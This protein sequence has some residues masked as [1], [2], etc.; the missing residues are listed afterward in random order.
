MRQVTGRERDDGQGSCCGE[1]VG[2]GIAHE[3]PRPAD[4]FRWV[5]VG[6][7]SDAQDAGQSLDP[8]GALPLEVPPRL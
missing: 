5:H 1:Y 7:W 8:V 2:V 6:G 4:M 3:S